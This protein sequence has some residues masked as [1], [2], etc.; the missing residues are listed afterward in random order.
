MAENA[1]KSAIITI[2]IVTGLCLIIS[3]ILMKPVFHVDAYPLAM[4]VPAFVFI[5]Y[6]ITMGEKQRPKTD[7]ALGW[8]LIVV[9]TT[10]I[11]DTAL[12]LAEIF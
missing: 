8:S 3:S 9:I 2:A 5:L 7:N 4:N 6:L 11:I 1:K 10:I 12:V